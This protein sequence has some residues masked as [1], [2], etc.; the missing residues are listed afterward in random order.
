MKK[1]VKVRG[2][3]QVRLPQIWFKAQSLGVFTVND[4][5]RGFP[6][7]KYVIKIILDVLVLMQLLKSGQVK[8]KGNELVYSVVNGVDEK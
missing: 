7:D 3:W 1:F 6:L 5:K 2:S 8:G 4:M